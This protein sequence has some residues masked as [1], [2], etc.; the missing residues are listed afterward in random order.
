VEASVALRFAIQEPSGVGEARRHA[1]ALAAAAD[2]DETTAGELSLVVTELATNLVKHA[3]G[4]GEVL[5]RAVGPGRRVAIEVLA[6]DRGP[7]IPNVA[8]A[9]RDRYSTAGTA[10]IGLGAVRRLADTFDI[11]S[12]AR[13]GTAVFARI[14]GPA[15]PAADG[16]GLRIRSGGFSVAK[17]G[18]E[19][20]GDGWAERRNGGTTRVIVVDGVG[21]GPEAARATNEAIRVFDAQPTAT[22]GDLLRA[23]HARLHD[24]RGASVAL[25]DLDAGRETLHFAGIGNIAGAIVTPG[26]EPQRHVVSQPG[27]VGHELARIHEY[28]YAWPTGSVLVLHSDGT[29]TRWTLDAY[30]GLVRRDPS[31]VAGVLYRDFERGNDDVTVVAFRAGRAA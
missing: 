21:H 14:E 9:L 18:E 27:T 3:H 17:R 28:D 11:H 4:G 12:D 5:L 6:L 1:A 16:P 15:G 24:T 13:H 7:G 31:L 10:G 2:Y 25:A 22:F 19:E 29:R 20:S 30:P 26:G 23:L 8:D